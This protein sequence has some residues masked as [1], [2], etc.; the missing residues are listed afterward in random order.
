MKPELPVA[1][2]PSFKSGQPEGSGEPGAEPSVVSALKELWEHILG[3]RCGLYD[4]FFDLGGGPAAALELFTGIGRQF[5][6]DLPLLVIFQAPTIAELAALLSNPGSPRIA[7]LTLLKPG[8]VSPP[9]FLAHGLGGS[10]LDFAHLAR[11][12]NCARSLYCLNT[13]GLD[14]AEPPFAS[15]EE[16]GAAGVR[17]IRGAQ[18]HGPYCLIGYSLGGLVMLETARQFEA[19]GEEISRLIMIDSYLHPKNMP[20]WLRGRLILRRA[21]RRMMERFQPRRIT[22]PSSALREF[23]RVAPLAAPGLAATRD[24]AHVIRLHYRPGA[25]LGP[26]TFIR[27]LD[28]P[29]FPVH[30]R[31]A[32]SKLIPNMTV[33]TAPGSHLE[34][35]TG[36]AAHLAQILNQFLIAP[37]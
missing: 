25:Y 14:G 27:S 33:E 32:W 17:A 2:P 9:V 7:P 19:S 34:L 28:T 4:N 26:V 5:G 20:Q 15:I 23:A 31:A 11:L 37:D 24:N 35:I 1:M 22:A 6:R 36:N 10:L 29:A 13:R 12:L 18:S 8:A 30:P 21:K 16:A 3:R